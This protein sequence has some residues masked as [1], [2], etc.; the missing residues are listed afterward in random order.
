M[1]KL[2]VLSL[3][4][5]VSCSK[6]PELTMLDRCIEVNKSKVDIEEYLWDVELKVVSNEQ[7]KQK[8]I[9]DWESY[10]GR[11]YLQ[12]VES[13]YFLGM[14]MDQNTGLDYFGDLTIGKLYSQIDHHLSQE[15]ITQTYSPDYEIT[16]RI[17]TMQR[18]FDYNREYY[19]ISDEFI[20]NK[21]AKAKCHSQGVY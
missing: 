5:I 4:L 13:G 7:L 6:E 8:W 16:F 1:N 9:N 18:H 21:E 11:N 20:L 12:D 3:F 10:E 19:G 2:L 15:E 14:G 17:N